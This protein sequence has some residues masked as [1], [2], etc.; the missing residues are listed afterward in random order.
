MSSSNANNLSFDYPAGFDGAHALLKHGLKIVTPAGDFGFFTFFF[1][2]HE[3]FFPFSLICQHF[4]FDFLHNSLH[5]S[6]DGRIRRIN[7]QG[8]LGLPQGGYVSFLVAPIPF[9]HLANG[10]LHGTLACLA[11]ELLEPTPRALLRGGVQVDLDLRI[12][13]NNGADVSPLCHHPTLGPI[14]PRNSTIL[15]LT[16]LLVEIL[17]ANWLSSGVRIRSVTSTPL[18]RTPGRPKC[19]TSSMLVCWRTLRSSLSSLRSIPCSITLHA[20]ARYMAPVSI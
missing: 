1:L 4:L 6:I 7:H 18:R 10:F 15:S 13:K 16:I 19:S 14:T 2:G 5:N 20:K 12:G 11:S 3:I 8:I 9:L 17:E